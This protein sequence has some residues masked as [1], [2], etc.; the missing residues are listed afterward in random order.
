M[1]SPTSAPRATRPP[2]WR[3]VRVLRVFIQIL[4]LAAVTGL[5]Y[6][7]WFNLTNNMR[8]I[9]IGTGF[10]FLDQP[11]GVRVTGS[12]LSPSASVRRALLVGMKNTFAAAAAGI[13]L[14]TVIG[15]I[16]GVARLSTNWLVAKVAAFYV[17]TLRNIPPLLVI[18]FAFNAAI[19]QLPPSR[20][21]ATPLDLFVIS[22]L[23][24]SVPWVETSQGAGPLWGVMA[25]AVV[26]A[27]LVWRWRT[28][29][30]ERTGEPHH[31]V[32]WAAG[33]FVLVSGAAWLLLGRPVRI[34][35]PT[36]EG[37]VATGGISGLGSYFAITL[38]LALYTAS[39][40]AEIV[41]GSILAVPRGQT[42]AAGALALSSFQRLRFVVLPQAMRIAI[43]P[44]INQY[45]NFVKNTSLGIAIGYAEITLVAFQAIG[46][47]RPAPQ[48]VLIL[49]G[50]YLVFSLTISALVNFLNRRLQYVT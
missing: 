25:A 17:E 10:G 26:V 19:L 32:L 45:L 50:V 20:D 9:G 23:R 27:A 6:V 43:P 42:E 3:D 5:L 35:I 18:I 22:N 21:P 11:V 34:S 15:V 41:R 24:I 2:L 7:L 46:N 14:L 29:V 37:R 13:P 40:V 8:R 4:T 38:A 47:A 30:E 31:R 48:L 33:L 12:D 1:T 28:G 44:I 16:V 36:L 49:M 39:H